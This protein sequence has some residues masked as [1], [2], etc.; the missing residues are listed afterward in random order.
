MGSVERPR[1]KWGDRRDGVWVKDAPGLNIVM[2]SLYPNRTDCEVYMR[3]EFDITELLRYIEE[4]NAQGGEVKTTL[5]HCFVSMVA[6]VV[7]ERPYL[8]RFVQGRRIYQRHEITVSFIAKRRF[9]D[10][11]EEV[12]MQYVAKDKDTLEDISRFIVGDVKKMRS[13]STAGGITDTI[14]WFGRLPRPILMLAIRVVRWL[15]F[16]GHVPKAL[17]DG[18]SNCAT[19]MM[20]N[21]GSIQCPS[22]Y[23]HLNN[24][25]T[26]SIFITIGKI[27]KAKI[28]K[29]DGT[30]EIRDFVDVGATLDERI[31]DGFYFA[32]SL[33]LIQHIC[34]H[35]ELLDLPLEE[36]SRY[37]FE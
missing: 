20:S 30:E 14:N 11:S 15:D 32:R 16:W 22:V 8:N 10:H 5:F 18:D 31:A 27:H 25:G 2:A 28:L 7:K 35:P 29:E 17:S 24:Y 36:E 12:L 34:S 23:H 13:S 37:D 21:L 3:Q 26:T 9:A 1:Q 4:K 33:K 19:V 6:R